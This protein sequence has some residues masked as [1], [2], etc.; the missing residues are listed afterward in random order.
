MEYENFKFCVNFFLLGETDGGIQ[1]SQFSDFELFCD[2][3]GA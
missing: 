2:I 1:F 3:A